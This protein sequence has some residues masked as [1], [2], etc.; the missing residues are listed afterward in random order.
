MKLSKIVQTCSACPS[1]WEG[2]LDDGQYFY[3]RFRGGHGTFSVG[4]SVDQA[5]C[6]W[7]VGDW[8][9]GS[10]YTEELFEVLVENGINVSGV[11]VLSYDAWRNL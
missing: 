6:E 1:Q 2:L 7:S 9:N 10:M 11:E 5:V 4:T 8:L 3:A